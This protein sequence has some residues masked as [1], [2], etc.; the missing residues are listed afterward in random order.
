MVRDT[1]GDGGN[2]AP[3]RV[4]YG[5]AYGRSQTGRLLRTL[6]YHDL[7]VDEQGHEALAGIIANTGTLYS[8]TG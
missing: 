4:R 3:G 6:V 8:L 5:Y 2:P 1:L 7:N